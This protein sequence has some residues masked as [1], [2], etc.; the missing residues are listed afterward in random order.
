[1]IVSV[2]QGEGTQDP[3]AT[4]RSSQ[5]E[6]KAFNDL[7]GEDQDK[8]VGRIVRRMLVR[9]VSR[10]P[11]RREELSKALGNDIPRKRKLLQEVIEST[12]RVFKAELGLEFVEIHRRIAHRGGGGGATQSAAT[13]AAMGSSTTA[14]I[15]ISALPKD[16][17]PE[18]MSEDDTAMLGFLTL[19]AALI[20]LEPGCRLSEADLFMSLAKLGLGTAAGA[21]AATPVVHQQLGDVRVLV[22]KTLPSQGY[23]EREKEGDSAV[24]LLG[25]RLRAE[26]SLEDLLTFVEMAFGSDLDATTRSELTQR[27]SLD[28][29]GATE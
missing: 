6:G 4:P 5:A 19:L 27:Y 1:M 15:L 12:K 20:L 28:V 13:N 23:L 14:Y 2:F 3:M 11:V 8:L 16:L 10:V 21:T 22:T 26:L 18:P 29:A 24:L 9:N 17:R 7:S 25:P